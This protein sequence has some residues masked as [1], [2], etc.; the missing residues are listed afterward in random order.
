MTLLAHSASG[1]TDDT[2]TAIRPGYHVV[3]PNCMELRNEGSRSCSSA[4]LVQQA[5]PVVDARRRQA[6]DATR[7]GRVSVAQ[8][9]LE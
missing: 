4:I 1:D 3:R 8:Q 5:I 6:S 9:P 2:S 7:T